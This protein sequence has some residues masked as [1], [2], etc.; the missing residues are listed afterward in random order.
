MADY[1]GAI[2]SASSLYSPVDAFSTKPLETTTTGAV[3]AG[4]STINVSST[5]GGF[6]A[7]YGVLSIDTN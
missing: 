4:D 6:A 7:G 3:N 1:P 5:S 2:D